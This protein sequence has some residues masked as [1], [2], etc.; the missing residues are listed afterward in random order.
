MLKKA[1]E[2]QGIGNIVVAGHMA[3]DAIGL[4]KIVEAW[5]KRRPRSH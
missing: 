1:V 3:S 2:E 4:N 5:E